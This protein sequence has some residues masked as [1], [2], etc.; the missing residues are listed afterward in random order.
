MNK[1]MLPYNTYVRCQKSLT[2]PAGGIERAGASGGVSYINDGEE[3]MGMCSASITAVS[4][5]FIRLA[6]FRCVN[7]LVAAGVLPAVLMVN[8]HLPVGIKEQ[9][10]KAA[11]AVLDELCS[12]SGMTLLLESAEVTDAVALSCY[13]LCAMGKVKKKRV[14]PM[15]EDALILVGSVASAGAA[16]LLELREQSLSERFSVSFIKEAKSKLSGFGLPKG[17]EEL[18]GDVFILPLAEAGLMSALW[19]LKSVWNVGFEVGLRAA[20]IEQEMV[21]ICEFLEI[22]P[23]HLAADGAAL[24]A[25][26]EPEPVL[27]F[28]GQKGIPACQIGIL[29]KGP[30]GNI[31][32]DDEISSVSRPKQDPIYNYV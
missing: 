6:F 5:S 12:A 13:S 7:G 8:V 16:L 27:S 21:E 26:R 18:T 1:G 20:H 24:L 22:N 14:G 32:K 23:Y 25:V 15:P 17:V 9:E 2:R 3:R 30:D 28:L 29:T 11:L 19:N 4:P 10:F 31:K